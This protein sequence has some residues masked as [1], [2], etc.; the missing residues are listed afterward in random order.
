[1]HTLYLKLPADLVARLR[2]LAVANDRTM[3][4]EAARAIRQ[5]LEAEQ[6][7]AERYD[8]GGVDPMYG[9]IPPDARKAKR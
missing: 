8:A 2:E 1:M 6:A 3:A 4:A 5:H 9:L 7:L